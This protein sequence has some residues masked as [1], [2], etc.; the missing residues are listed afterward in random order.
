LSWER[1]PLWA[2]AKLYFRR[3]FSVPRDDPQFGV[4]CSLGLELLGRAAVASVSPTLLADPDKH[5]QNILHALGRGS[6]KASPK[7]IGATR[8]FQLCGE[9]S[10]KFTEEDITAA[11][12]LMNRRNDELHSGNSAFEEYPSKLWLGGFFGACQSLCNVLGEDLESLFGKDEAD[13]AKDIL[14][15]MKGHAK[16]RVLSLIA[17]HR[18]VFEGKAD[19]E[20][21]IAIEAAEKNAPLLSAQHHHRVRC[22]ACEN[23]SFVQGAVFGS[24]HIT[25]EDHAVFVRQPVMPKSFYCSVCGLK[26]AGYSELQEAGLG[27]QY[28]RTTEYSPEEFYGLISPDDVDRDAIIDDYLNDLAAESEWDNE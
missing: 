3:A 26:L 15:E 22:P 25:S 10:D 23:T 5:Q 1:D 19:A 28:N 7:S 4:W 20:K 16:Q 11:N 18:R 21:L 12:A 17:A 24:Q 13:I 27:G 8:V 14:A 2:K 6:G 9:L